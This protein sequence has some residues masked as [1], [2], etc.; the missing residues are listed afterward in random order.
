M[1]RNKEKSL[2]AICGV[3]LSGGKRL[4]PNPVCQQC[5]SRAL[6][7]NGEKAKWGFEYVYE[8]QENYRKALEQKRRYYNDESIDA[9]II[10]DAG[11]NPV[12]IDGRKCWRRYRFGGY[13]TM[14]DDH[15]CSDISE[16]Y[17]KHN[18]SRMKAD[19]KT[20]D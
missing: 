6:N 5:D 3:E 14:K 7:A 8:T 11:E 15:D 1:S 17:R 16:F 18:K 9:I 10:P 19:E 4:Y 20:N 12:F 13:L 2:C